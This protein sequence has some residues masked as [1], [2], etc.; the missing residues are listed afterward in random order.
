MNRM[1]DLR[2]MNRRHYK[3]SVNEVRAHLGLEQW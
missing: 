3:P 2:M 1:K